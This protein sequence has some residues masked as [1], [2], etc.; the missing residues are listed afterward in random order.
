MKAVIQARD[1]FFLVDPQPH[2]RADYLQQDEGDDGAIDDGG[3]DAF[4]LDQDL[5]GVSFQKPRRAADG[6]DGED[7]GQQRPGNAAQAVNAENVQ[8]V[9]VAE[10]RLQHHRAPIADESGDKAN[11]QGGEGIDVAG[12]R[13]DGDEAGD[14]A[15][16][17]AQHAGLAAA[18]PLDN[19]PRYCRRRG[20][21]LGHGHG[22]AGAAV[23]GDRRSGVETEP[24]DPQHG[25]A[26][27]A[28]DQVMGRHVFGAVTAAAA[29]HH[30]ADQGGDAGIDVDHGAAGEVE[31]A[32]IGQK[33]ATP[34]PMGDRRVNDDHPQP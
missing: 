32:G 9:V 34:N 15:G 22:H 12:R 30:R 19:H 33:P 7:A 13:G 8:A 20:R 6:L 29:Q 10:L 27:D 11:D 24:A 16:N 26:D 28:Q 31:N 3:G 1:L 18:N 14:G 23:G 17:D 2:H 4:Q 5:S 21:D 25:G